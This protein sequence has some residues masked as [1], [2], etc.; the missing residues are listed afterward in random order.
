MSLFCDVSGA[1]RQLFGK[2]KSIFIPVS[3]FMLCSFPNAKRT[4][5]FSGSIYLGSARYFP[6]GGE[7]AR[8]RKNNRRSFD[9]VIRKM[10]E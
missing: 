2:T 1:G 9:C 5:P 6:S 10:R 3:V 4:L 8:I 7:G